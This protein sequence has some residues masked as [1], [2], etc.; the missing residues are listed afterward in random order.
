MVANLVYRL[1]LVVNAARK[2]EDFALIEAALPAGVA[3]RRLP[4]RALLAFQGPRAAEAIATLAPD[5][6]ALSFMGVAETRVAGI[7]VLASRSGYTGEDGFEIS[8]PAEEV[9]RLA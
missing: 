5:L 2:E 1:F 9:E 8:A 4:D 6:A 7:P 3:L